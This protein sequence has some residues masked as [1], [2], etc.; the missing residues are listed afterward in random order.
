[1]RSNY[2]L[3]SWKTYC[4]PHLSNTTSAY[5]PSLSPMD[6]LWRKVQK[7]LTQSRTHHILSSIHEHI[8]YYKRAG[9]QRP[10]PRINLTGSTKEVHRTFSCLANDWMCSTARVNAALCSWLRD[11]ADGRCHSSGDKIH[12]ASSSDRHIAEVSRREGCRKCL[13][14][15]LYEFSPG[16]MHLLFTLHI[17]RN[18]GGFLSS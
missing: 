3:F 6:A 2:N 13:L 9:R 14:I 17:H 18:P 12:A 15:Y 11:S 5:A 4:R 10:P 7:S 16:C 8:T 1:M